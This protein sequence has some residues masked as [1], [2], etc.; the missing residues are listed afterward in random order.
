MITS[1]SAIC[2][3]HGKIGVAGHS[4]QNVL[5]RS[6]IS[7]NATSLKRNVPLIRASLIGLGLLS[8]V[9]TSELAAEERDVD[10][11]MAFRDWS[12]FFDETD[13]WMASH[14]QDAD[15]NFLES[16]LFMISF[17]GGSEEF[18]IS[19]GFDYLLPENL[20][21]EV[22]VDQ[23][24][25]EFFVHEDSIF[26]VDVIDAELFWGLFHDR[27]V[28]IELTNAINDKSSTFIS[29]AGFRIAY[30]FVVDG[31]TFNSRRIIF[32]D[33]LEEPA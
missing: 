29:T 23:T 27:N 18:E 4:G 28:R 7:S 32:G 12:A 21:A 26:P 16:M 24:A 17:H 2:P 8:L 9:F 31:C 14:P 1:P 6:R 11:T 15:G 20:Y 33:G 25:Y 13:C 10:A 30:Q 3:L 22:Y 5:I 19:I